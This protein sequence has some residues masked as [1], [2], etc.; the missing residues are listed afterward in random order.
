MCR[1]IGEWIDGWIDEW[2]SGWMDGQTDRRMDG[3][4]CRRMSDMNLLQIFEGLSITSR[5]VEYLFSVGPEDKIFPDS[6]GQ[7]IWPQVRKEL[8]KDSNC[9]WWNRWC[10]ERASP[11]PDEEGEP[12]GWSSRCLCC[13]EQGW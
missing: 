4:V 5:G 7:Q 8:Y 11:C 13:Q 1:W 9:F 3:R 12:A 2:V 6:L 10:G